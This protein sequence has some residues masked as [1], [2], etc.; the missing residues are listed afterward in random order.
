MRNPGCSVN[1]GKPR[2]SLTLNPGYDSY[3]VSG[4]EKERAGRPRSQGAKSAGADRD[5]FFL[6]G[7]FGGLWQP[8]A[9]HALFELRFDL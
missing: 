1:G 4:K 5:L 3:I 2:V 9:Q 7:D 8:D 6:L